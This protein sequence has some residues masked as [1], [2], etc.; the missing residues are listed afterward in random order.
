MKKIFTLIAMALVAVGAN[1][2]DWKATATAPAAGSELINN[3]LLKVNTSYGTTAAHIQDPA[4]SSNI[5][6]TMG[7]YSFDYYI[8]VRTADNATTTSDGGEQSGSTP[9]IITAK[10]AVD[11]T[12]YYR[13]QKGTNG[14]DKDDNKDILC[15]SQSGGKMESE[16]T[17]SS[18]TTGGEYGYAIKTYKFEAGTYVLYRKGSTINFYGFK[19]AE[20]TITPSSGPSITA[21]T[22]FISWSTE[23]ALSNVTTSEMSNTGTKNNCATWENGF[24]IMIMRSDKDMS[25]GSNITVAGSQYKSMKVSNGAQNLLTLPEGFVASGITFYSY[26]NNE[27]TGWEN[28]YWKEVA[29]TTYDASTM[30]SCKDGAN[31]DEKSFTFDGN[32]LNKITFT[33]A[34]KQ[35]CYVV[36]IDIEAGSPTDI[37]N[38]KTAT[39]DLSNGEVYNLAGQKVDASAKGLVIKNGK[40]MIQK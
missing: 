23:P 20:G 36:K 38:A 17:I 7:G 1:A 25:S 3:D 11:L 30:T 34:G 13:R 10:K 8:N 5:E 32:K 16:I 40:K 31:P 39:I 14:F 28:S 35:L 21:G 12:I 24:S 27:D 18:Q 26:V 6:V 33:N 37:K 15:V 19:A 4:T 2:Q 9:L 29:G 22:Y